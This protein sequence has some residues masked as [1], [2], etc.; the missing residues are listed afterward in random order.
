LNFKQRRLRI[1]G[2]FFYGDFEVFALNQ[3]TVSHVLIK[4]HGQQ[5]LLIVGGLAAHDNEAVKQRQTLKQTQ[6]RRRRI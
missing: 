4:H 5:S 1:S 6:N 3:H 2:A